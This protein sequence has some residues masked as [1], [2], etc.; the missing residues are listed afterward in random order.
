MLNHSTE[1]YGKKHLFDGEEETC[2]NS[3]PGSPQFVLI[4]FKEP[5]QVEFVEILGQGGF[6]PKVLNI[7]LIGH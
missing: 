1:E 5:T 3:E 6:C 7:A 2:W 4:I